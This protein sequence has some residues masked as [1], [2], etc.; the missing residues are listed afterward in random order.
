MEISK[1]YLLKNVLSRPFYN[2]YLRVGQH[3]HDRDEDGG[4]NVDGGPD[5]VH[6]DGSWQVG[7]LPAKI[8]QTS[9][10]QAD[11]Q[12]GGKA[13]VVDQSVNVLRCQ[14]D[15]RENA[16]E[17]NGWRRSE[18]IHLNHRQNFRHLL[19]FGAGVEQSERAVC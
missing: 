2:I 13:D 19:L 17:D 4:G 9:D 3:W 1:K 14:V 12:P 10:S 11:G 5:K 16:H 8:R 7:F 6:L 15:Q 18:V